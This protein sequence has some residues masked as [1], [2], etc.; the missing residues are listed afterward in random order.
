MGQLQTFSIRVDDRESGVAVLTALR[1]YPE[2]DVQV[3]RLAV[4]DYLVEERL[5]FER[6]TLPDLVASIKDGRLFA[7]GERLAKAVPRGALILEGTSSDLG[8]TRMSR[9][10]IQGAL[11]SLALFYDLP[12]L[13]A[14]DPA[15]TARLML[16]AARQA[17]AFARGAIPRH[18][19][20]PRGKSRLQSH[21]LQGLPRI[22]PERAKRLI[23]HFGSVEAVIAA[24]AE[25]LMQVRGI[26]AEVAEVIRWAVRDEPVSYPRRGPLMP[27]R[28]RE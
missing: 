11:V 21:I 5:L 27:A 8:A 18:G 14:T 12:L 20:R 25:A 28:H 17:R 16:F 4:G 22:G 10:A 6:K 13:R 9:E 19:R 7:Q 15:E 3:E 26:G 24:D 23:D 2:F 1:G